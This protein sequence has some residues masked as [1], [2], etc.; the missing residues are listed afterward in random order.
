MNQPKFKN[1]SEKQEEQKGSKP[2]TVFKAVNLGLN[3]NEALIKIDEKCRQMEAE[4][5]IYKECISLS[6]GEKI[7]VFGVRG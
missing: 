4:G 7:L 3:L 2:K 5:Y 1:G 6:A